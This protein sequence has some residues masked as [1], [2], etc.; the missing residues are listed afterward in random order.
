MGRTTGS[1]SQKPESERKIKRPIHRV[2]E[3]LLFVLS[4]IAGYWL[5]EGL[6]GSM[7]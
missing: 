6:V 4:A 2:G 3:V 7:A 1:E 5:V